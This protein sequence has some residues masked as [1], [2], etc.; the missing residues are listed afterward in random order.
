M[1]MQKELIPYQKN[2][3]T[4]LEKSGVKLV[5]SYPI[6]ED[7]AQFMEHPMCREFYE[8]Y[9]KNSETLEK[10][11][12]MLFLYEKIDTN[13]YINLNG[14]QKVALLMEIIIKKDE[15]KKQQIKL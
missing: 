5:N 7:I 13:T 11:L 2:T 15:L 3:L 1:K 4:E 12:D 14:F 10:M 6:L 9:M 8:K